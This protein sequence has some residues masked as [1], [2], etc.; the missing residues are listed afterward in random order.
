M[1]QFSIVIPLYNKKAFVAEALHSIAGQNAWQQPHAPGYEIIVVDDASTDGSTEVV[2]A[3]QWPTIRL[4]NH[5]HNQGLSA[6][7]N[8]GI[9]AA[10]APWILF[11]D[12]DDVWE[13]EFMTAI[14]TMMKAYPKE[15]VLATAYVEWDGQHTRTP[16]TLAQYWPHHQIQYLPDVFAVNKT[17]GLFVHSGIC[18]HKEVFAKVG[19]YNPD[20]RFAEDLDFNI[21]CLMQYRLVFYNAPL[22]RYRVGV[23]GQLTQAS[24]KGKSI[25]NYNLYQP[26]V[27]ERPSLGPYLDFERYVLAKHLKTDGDARYKAIAAAIQPAH[28]RPTQR[29]LLACP[30]GILRWIVRIKKFLSRIGWR[31]HTY[32]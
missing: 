9:E 11:L 19:T 5:T 4:L 25:P 16:A 24:I 22:L 8:T 10:Q 31:V 21:R 13:P 20:I 32:G 7:R 28:L 23:P 29:L 14:R 1:V 15:K 2:K 3:L 6:A 30:A 18:F 12:A 17:Q 27:A 26:W